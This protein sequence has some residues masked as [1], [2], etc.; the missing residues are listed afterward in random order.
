MKLRNDV[1]IYFIVYTTYISNLV[2]VINK[3]Y[4]LFVLNNFYDFN[5]GFPKD[6]YPT[7]FINQFVDACARNEVLS[8]MNEF[9]GHKKVQIHKN[10]QYK[11]TFTILWRKF[12]W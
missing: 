6:N 4:T 5:L 9:L 11:T 10:D 8:F 2:L 12:S 3:K 7:L 1:L